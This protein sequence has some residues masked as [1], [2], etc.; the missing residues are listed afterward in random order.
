MIAKQKRENL[1]Q[2]IVALNRILTSKKYLLS[3]QIIK[4]I[5]SVSS[6]IGAQEGLYALHQIHSDLL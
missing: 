5:F 2:R 4:L 3:R 1:S 6:R